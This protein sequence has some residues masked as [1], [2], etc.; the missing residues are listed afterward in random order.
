MQHGPRFLSHHV[1]N[2]YQSNLP[3]SVNGNSSS[4]PSHRS[5][6]IATTNSSNSNRYNS[7]H[8]H[9]NNN[10]QNV[11]HHDSNQKGIIDLTANFHSS[12]NAHTNKTAFKCSNFES[13]QR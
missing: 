9:Y 2:D 10:H 11:N 3:H 5:S 8:A 4:N 12:Y 6:T 13:H 7:N 1:L